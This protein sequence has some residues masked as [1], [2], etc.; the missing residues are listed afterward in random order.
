MQHHEDLVE[1]P[2]G[3]RP[4]FL[5]DIALDEFEVPI[6]EPVPHE[7]VDSVRRGIEAQVR[8]RLVERVLG[9]DDLAD[10]PLVDRQCRSGRSDART[11]PDADHSVFFLPQ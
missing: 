1:R 11:R 3:D 10:D 5:V 4:S 6:A 2:A 8:Q 9:L 7:M